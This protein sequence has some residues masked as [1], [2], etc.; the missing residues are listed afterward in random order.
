MSEIVKSA[1]IKHN[2]DDII[3]LTHHI[4]S[5]H[6]PM[7]ISNRAAQFAPFAALKGYNNA[8]TETEKANIDAFRKK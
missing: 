3:H 7:S 2:Y 5:N 6:T 4:S 1:D 8:I